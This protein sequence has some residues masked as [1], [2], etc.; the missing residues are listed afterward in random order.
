M[1][2]LSC[3][4]KSAK[5]NA[6]FSNLWTTKLCQ[7]LTL[8]RPQG[9]KVSS[10]FQ[11][12][13]SRAD[14]PKRGRSQRWTQE[15]QA[16][17]RKEPWLQ[18]RTADKY[19][20]LQAT[21]KSKGCLDMWQ[22]AGPAAARGVSPAPPRPSPAHQSRGKAPRPA[23]NIKQIQAEVSRCHHLPLSHGHL[24]QRAST[25]KCRPSEVLQAGGSWEIWVHK[26]SCRSLWA[27]PRLQ[28]QPVGVW[29]GAQASDW[30]TRPSSVAYPEP[31]L[32]S[33]VRGQ[34]ILASLSPDNPGAMWSK[35]PNNIEF[36][37]EKKIL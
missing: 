24:Q 31:A 14:L 28:H 23:R 18:A 36:S 17:K 6:E 27:F 11:R 10:P 4:L 12:T 1:L 7:P 13:Q 16:P 8:L 37:K 9:V 35:C 33:C 5:V 3:G 21:F 22:T 26:A 15:P 29:A 19:E 34:G 25:F 20:L 2:S 32:K 30:M